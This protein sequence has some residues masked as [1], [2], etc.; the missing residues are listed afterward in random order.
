MCY[1]SLHVRWLDAAHSIVHVLSAVLCR[2]GI[3]STSQTHD[4]SNANLWLAV[5]AGWKGE[6]ACV[7]CNTLFLFWRSTPASHAT[8]FWCC[9]SEG[10]VR[11]MMLRP[12]HNFK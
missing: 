4:V 6:I 3:D 8:A 5:V 10:Y 9:G 7:V 12:A 2:C 11:L 1:R